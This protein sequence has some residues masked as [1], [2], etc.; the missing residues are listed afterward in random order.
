MR[1][2]RKASGPR[3][4]AQDSGVAGSSFRLEAYV[5]TPRSALPHSFR[6]SL[7][8]TPMTVSRITQGACCALLQDEKWEQRKLTRANPSKGGDAKPPVYRTQ[9]LRQRGYQSNRTC[10]SKRSARARDS[11]APADLKRTAAA[12]LPT[13]RTQA[14]VF[15]RSASLSRIRASIFSV[16]AGNE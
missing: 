12:S 3:I 8:K 1:R 11:L 13:E 4:T 5:V 9:V 15:A 16:E 7:L 14:V 2:G 6:Q 10:N